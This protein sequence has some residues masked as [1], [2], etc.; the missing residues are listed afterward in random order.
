VL[1][2]SAVLRVSGRRRFVAGVSLVPIF[3]R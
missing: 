1:L 2:I 3:F